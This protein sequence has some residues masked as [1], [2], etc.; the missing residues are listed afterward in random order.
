MSTKY[1]M[2]NSKYGPAGDVPSTSP[3]TTEDM[4]RLIMDE[5]K[6]R[7]SKHYSICGDV[8]GDI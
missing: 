2:G 7:L 6:E 4:L 5:R 3:V 8:S 1:G